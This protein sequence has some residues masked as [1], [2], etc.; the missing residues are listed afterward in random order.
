MSRKL[1][2]SP[3]KY[4]SRSSAIRSCIAPGVARRRVRLTPV[5]FVPSVRSSTPP[6]E[7]ARILRSIVGPGDPKGRAR[8]PLCAGLRRAGIGSGGQNVRPSSWA[9]ARRSSSRFRSFS[10]RSRRS[11]AF[12]WMIL[13]RVST[14]FFPSSMSA[15]GWAAFSAALSFVRSRSRSAWRRDA[16]SRVSSR[17]AAR[18][19]S[20][21]SS[22]S[23]RPPP[24]PSRPALP[25]A[26]VR[27]QGA[28]LRPCGFRHVSVRRRL[29][30]LGFEVLSEPLESG[31]ALPQLRVARGKGLLPPPPGRI[32]G[33]EGPF[34]RLH[35]ALLPAEVL[36]QV[37]RPL[38]L[39]GQDGLP[40][41]EICRLRLDRSGLRVQGRLP[42][43]QVCGEGREPLCL[44]V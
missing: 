30:E 31:H 15:A 43:A 2:G 21:M 5:S 40:L 24:P 36:H 27:L 33:R 18:D 3:R 38:D 10:S 28:R 42:P 41:D 1:T 32:A 8:L 16:F 39:R 19:F 12:F 11:N 22:A 29:P 4:R 35:L 20:F 6:I 9:F 25:P 34:P 13:T 7:V 44:P 37:L 14:S 23:P 17:S 26:R